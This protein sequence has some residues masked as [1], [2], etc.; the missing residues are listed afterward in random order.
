MGV[1]KDLGLTREV[2]LDTLSSDSQR[3]REVIPFPDSLGEEAVLKE[4]FKSSR[5]YLKGKGVLISATPSLGNKVIM[6]MYLL[7][8]RMLVRERSLQL[9]SGSDG[10]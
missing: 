5:G 9:F 10:L 7:I 6:C 2:N 8:F 1:N 4:T 3:F